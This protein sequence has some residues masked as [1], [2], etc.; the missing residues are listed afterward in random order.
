MQLAKEQHD[1][2][3]GSLQKARRLTRESFGE[4]DVRCARICLMLGQIAQQRGRYDDAIDHFQEAWEVRE[5]VNGPDAEETVRLNLRMAEVQH[6]DGRVDEA[7]DSQMQVVKKLQQAVT[8]PA[9]LVQASSQLA[10]WLE[11][12]GRDTEA[13]EVLKA[14]EATASENL[15]NEN[16]K[17]VAVKRDIALLY[18]KLGDSTTA[19][20][21]LND[22]HYFERCL[23]GSQSIPVGRTLKALGTVHMVRKNFYE[24]EQ[25]LSQALR[26]FEGDHPINHAIIRD[27]HAKLDQMSRS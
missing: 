18:L 11:A 27:I 25:C 24:A 20:Q 19:L 22:V 2:A 4:W 21:C 10:Q 8:F 7:L 9:L 12:G 1:A 5:Y 17:A 15:G 14:A 3:R 23:H 26:I 16:E 6:L 13:L